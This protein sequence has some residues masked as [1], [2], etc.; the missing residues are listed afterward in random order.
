MLR[1]LV[2][3]LILALF[4]FGPTAASAGPIFDVIVPTVY[5]VDTVSNIGNANG[6]FGWI[7]STSDTITLSDLTSAII[8]HS[9]DDSA[10]TVTGAMINEG[11][12]APLTVGEVGGASN[13]LNPAY[14]AFLLGGESLV[15]PAVQLWGLTLHYPDS[16]VGTATLDTTLQIG[17]QSVTFQTT[18]Q[19]GNLP[20]Q[21]RAAQRLTSSPVPEPSTALLIAL[22]IGGLAAMRRS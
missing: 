19:L 18:V 14:N 15:G 20:T 10:V 21:Y 12:F 4:V 6:S 11:F 13:A 17:D 8:S 7:I 1:S 2:L 22:G 5:R 9:I 16:Y 3:R